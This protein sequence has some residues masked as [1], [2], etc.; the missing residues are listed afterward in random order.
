LDVVST[1]YQEQTSARAISGTIAA[2]VILPVTLPVSREISRNSRAHCM[3]KHISASVA[4]ERPTI[5][6]ESQVSTM[7]MRGT[8]NTGNAER[9]AQ[10]KT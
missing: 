7:T 4:T 2:E 3:T 8:S 9:N 1:E 6:L 5:T 10:P